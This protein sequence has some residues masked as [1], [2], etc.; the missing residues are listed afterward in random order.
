[1]VGA[2]AGTSCL[3]EVANKPAAPSLRAR[4]CCRMFH[5]DPLCEQFLA[6]RL[7]EQADMIAFVDCPADVLG[8]KRLFSSP[9]IESRGLVPREWSALLG[10][11]GLEGYPVGASVDRKHF[12]VGPFPEMM[13]A[14]GVGTDGADHQNGGE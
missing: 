1:M 12:A 11:A 4:L 10:T 8:G 13:R 14:D 2:G 7:V 9:G 5:D 6:V 3:G